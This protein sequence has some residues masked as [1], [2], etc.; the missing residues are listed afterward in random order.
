MNPRLKPDEE[1]NSSIRSGA[2]A[3]LAAELDGGLGVR[4]VNEVSYKVDI[5]HNIF[6]KIFII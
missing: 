4:I 3:D 6:P 1:I 2:D 5:Y